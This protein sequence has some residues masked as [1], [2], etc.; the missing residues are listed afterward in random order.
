LTIREGRVTNN[1]SLAY[2]A[3]AAAVVWFLPNA[4]ELLRNY[5]PGIYTFQV[6]STTPDLLRLKWRPTLLWAFF[7]GGIGVWILFSLTA[8]KPFVYGG[9]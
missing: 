9:F 4:Y 6:P 1:Q 7:Y 5:R 3:T 8:Q 2:L